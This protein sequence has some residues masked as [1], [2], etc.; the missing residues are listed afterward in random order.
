[1]CQVKPK[2]L[3]KIYCVEPKQA[4]CNMEK[5]RQKKEKFSSVLKVRENVTMRPYHQL[6]LKDIEI[7]FNRQNFETESQLSM[8]SNFT[9]NVKYELK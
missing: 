6:L 1:M 2:I 8:L 7:K 4:S 3:E 9:L 5:L